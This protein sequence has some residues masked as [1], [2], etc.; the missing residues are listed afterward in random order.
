MSS[1]YVRDE[2]TAFLTTTFPTEKQI[3]L[4]AEYRELD[5]ALAD[6]G[7]GRRD[8]WLGL[9]FIG[10]DEIPISIGG[11]EAKGCYRE[12]GSIF[13]HI[14]APVQS[15][16]S[17]LILTRAEAF[18]NAF[19]AKRINEV[20]IESVTPANFENGATLEFEGGFTS[21]SCILTYHR[22]LNT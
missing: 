17:D 16:V 19:R 10:S 1:I 4:T 21:A 7:I 3:D 9:Q 15:G 11:A 8:N 14:V 18:R 20:V 12:V 6:A 2:L 13:L 5:E 22:D